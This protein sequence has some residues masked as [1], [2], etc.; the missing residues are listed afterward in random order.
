MHTHTHTLRH[1]GARQLI[2]INIADTQ[3]QQEEAEEAEEGSENVLPEEEAEEGRTGRTN[4]DHHRIYISALA[5]ETMSAQERAAT[6]S[7]QQ[8]QVQLSVHVV[9]PC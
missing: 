6:T 7:A 5:V 9:Q 8:P 1:I 2:T 3:E 4:G